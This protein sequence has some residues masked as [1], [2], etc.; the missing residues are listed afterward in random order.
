MK[1]TNVWVREYKSGA[2]L[3]F[4]DVQ[5]SLDDGN[6]SH[7]TWKGFKLFQGDN[8][9]IQIGLPS[10]KDDKGKKDEKTGKDIYHP[11]ITIPF[12]ED[13]PNNVGKAFFEE[14]RAACEKAYKN[15]VNKASVQ[16]ND[17]KDEVTD[18]DCPF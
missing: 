17:S 14:M 7:M 5:F 1:V 9:D 12:S 3:G 8:G 4:A 2:L 16:S 18:D 13:Q 15:L 10:K 11:V 6:E